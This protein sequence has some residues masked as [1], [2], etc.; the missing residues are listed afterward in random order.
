M[1]LAN[2]FDQKVIWI[3]GASGGLGRELAIALAQYNVRIILSSRQEDKLR[4]TQR[5]ANLP[6][7]R[8]LILPMDL[9]SI[10]EE[11][12]KMI[13]DRILLKFG[14]LDLLIHNA[15]LSQRSMAHQT[16]DEVDRKIMETNFFG[17]VRLTKYILPTLLKSSDPKIIVISSLAGKFGVPLRSTYCAAKHA[18]HGFFDAMKMELHKKIKVTF[19]VLGGVKTE[20]AMHALNADGTIHNQLDLWHERNMPADKCAKEI[21]QKLHSNRDEWV[22]GR[23]EKFGLWLKLHF[24]TL[25]KKVLFSFYAKDKE[26]LDQ[27]PSID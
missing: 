18:L 24:P 23:V 25:H 6:P 1:Q 11:Q 13:G 12:I 20:S 21:I 10:K 15:S 7:E 14:K 22:I 26:N 8:C 19:F 2:K 5:L 4:E 16:V 17:P 27:E 9:T 3:T